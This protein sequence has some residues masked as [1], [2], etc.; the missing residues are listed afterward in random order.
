MEK[1]DLELKKLL[2]FIRK[3]GGLG[4]LILLA[5][6][7]STGIYTV[8]PDETALVTVFGKYRKEVGSGMSWNFPRPIGRVYKVKSTNVYREELGFKTIKQGESQNIPH[9]SL[10]LTKDENIVEIDLIIQYRIINVKKFLF[11]VKNPIQMVRSAGEASIRAV[12]GNTELTDILTTGKG[13]IQEETK[14]MIQELLDRYESGLMVLNVQLQDVQPPQQVRSAFRDVASAREDRI[15]YI[16]EANGYRN[17]ILPRARGEARKIINQALAFKEERINIAHGDTS[18]FLNLYEGYKFGEEANKT[19]LYLE[20]LEKTL[21]NIDK[22]II[23]SDIESNLIN[24]LGKGG[25]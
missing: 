6:Y 10:M 9:E 16:N 5:F 17:D 1:K 3:L 7:F 19:R 14:L 2:D 8:G 24:I 18:R 4:I 13:L 25:L 15:R 11:N 20:T 23:D 22:I 21:P 12:I